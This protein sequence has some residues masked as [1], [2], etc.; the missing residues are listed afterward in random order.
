MEQKWY[1]FH[2]QNRL[3]SNDF[4]HPTW[5]P[6]AA[7]ISCFPALPDNS[8]FRQRG[9]AGVQVSAPPPAAAIPASNSMKRNFYPALIELLGSMDTRKRA[10]KNLIVFQKI[11][12]PRQDWQSLKDCQSYGSYLPVNL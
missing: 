7:R 8:D 10:M 3:K 2:H 11:N 6:V 12:F 5:Y 9:K 4:H 1:L